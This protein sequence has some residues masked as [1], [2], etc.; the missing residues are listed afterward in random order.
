VSGHAEVTLLRP[1]VDDAARQPGLY[2][3]ASVDGVKRRGDALKREVLAP[4]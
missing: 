1:R 2:R 3:E 4:A